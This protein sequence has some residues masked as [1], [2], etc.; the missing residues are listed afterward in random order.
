[1]AAEEARVLPLQE[2][3]AEWAGDLGRFTVEVHRSAQGGELRLQPPEGA[4]LRIELRGDT[5]T[6]HYEGP[7]ARLQAPDAKLELSARDIRLEAEQTLSLEGR[8]E[9]DIHSR[10][11]V[12]IRADHHVNLWGHGVQVGD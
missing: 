10:A 11:D 6:L 2:R 4:A 7:E 3:A 12:E 8:E 5:L 9:V 1:M